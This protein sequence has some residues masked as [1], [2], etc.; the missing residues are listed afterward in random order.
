MTNGENMAN[1][2]LQRLVR[3]LNK[4]WSWQPSEIKTAADAY[5]VCRTIVEEVN[6]TAVS[7]E[8]RTQWRIK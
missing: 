6:N 8:E 3:E 5:E 2:L 1:I 4:L 7:G